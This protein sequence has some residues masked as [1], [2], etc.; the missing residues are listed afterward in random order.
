MVVPIVHF[1]ED[2]SLVLFELSKRIGLD[3]L[4]LVSLALELGVELLYKI[5]LLLE[6]LF[7]LGKDGFFNLGR[8]FSEILKDFS[9]FLH[10]SVLLSF[11]VDKVLAHLI[12]NWFKLIVETL[13]AIT[14]LLGKQV[15]QV[16]HPIVASFVF[17]HLVLVLVVILVFQLG[18]E[19]LE[20][21]VILDL[22][23]LERVVDLLAFVDSVLLDI[24]DFSVLK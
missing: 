21:L 15:L 22:I 20:L 19:I 5:S 3:L 14:T 7:L 8:F 12:M 17:V 4:D 1:L 18:V 9:F 6:T 2:V 13:N 24:L 10:T 16:C 23:G 11:Q